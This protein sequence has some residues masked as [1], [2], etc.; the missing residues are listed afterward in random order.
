MQTHRAHKHT[1]T[2]T[3]LHLHTHIVRVD[4]A[5]TCQRPNVSDGG[6][7]PPH[8]FRTA[9][10]GKLNKRGKYKPNTNTNQTQLDKQTLQHSQLRSLPPTL[11]SL[12][13]S[14]CFLHHSLSLS[15]THSLTLPIS[16]TPALS[17]SLSSTYL[18]PSFSLSFRSLE[19]M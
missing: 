6:V 9:R 4:E 17:L 11:A 13:L 15:L 3:H 1:H 12:S 14:L 7:A 2:Q 8:Q 5:T 10:Q 19:H 18:T 16:L